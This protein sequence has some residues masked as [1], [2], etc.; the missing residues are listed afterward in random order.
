VIWSDFG[1]PHDLVGD[2]GAE[3]ILIGFPEARASA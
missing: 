3:A 2:A 1:E